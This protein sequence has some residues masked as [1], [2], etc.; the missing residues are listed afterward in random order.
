MECDNIKILLSGYLDN[1]LDA[2]EK[3]QVESHLQ[4]C[5][6]CNAELEDLRNYLDVARKHER[7]SPPDSLKDSIWQGIEGMP[8]K[9]AVSFNGKRILWITGVAAAAAIILYFSIL[10]NFLNTTKLESDFAYQEIKRGKAP[11]NKK[12]TLKDESKEVKWLT[13]LV[14]EL[15]GEILE[16]G[17]NKQ[18]GMTDYT[19]FRLRKKR[20]IQLMDSLH[21]AGIEV[22]LPDSL[23][24]ASG[25]VVIQLY[26]PGRKFVTGDFNGDGRCDLA[27][28][29]MRG[30]NAGEWFI[31]FNEMEEMFA[32]PSP[33]HFDDGIFYLEEDDFP[34]SGDLDG[35]H[36]PDL[37]IAN[38]SGIWITFINDG[39]TPYKS[40]DSSHLTFILPSPGPYIPLTGDINND[41]LDDLVLHFRKGDLAGKWFVALNKGKL[42][43]SD[44]SEFKVRDQVIQENSRY[45][46]FILDYNGD[47]YDDCG[48]YWQD[49]EFIA[50]WFI[51]LNDQ[52]GGFSEPS[53][54]WFGNSPRA[55]L[56]DYICFT[57][58]F[59][60]DGYGDLLVKGG[61]QDETGEWYLMKNEAGTKFTYGFGVLFNGREH[62]TIEQ[63]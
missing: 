56:G 40:R 22:T 54:I 44:F 45:I 60:A 34:L 4:H 27:A 41:Q 11:A 58:D 26:F 13:G 18:T 48:I 10:P 5:E 21:E 15:D 17:F 2:A 43:F 50:R 25:Y 47:G 29:Y 38:P 62:F 19:R 53:Q 55:F 6:A 3:K 49:G 28:Y 63:Q 39:V 32:E 20:Y 23:E 46:P 7:K 61:T 24:A 57:G 52:N 59:T 37:V 42:M 36:L 35:D 16:E 30:K 33:V 1:E 31:T 51:A 8:E 12:G 14:H 9:K